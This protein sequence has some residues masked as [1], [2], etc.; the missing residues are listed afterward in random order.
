MLGSGVG[1]VVGDAVT[2]LNVGSTVGGSVGVLVGAILG[3]EKGIVEKNGKGQYRNN[4]AKRSLSFIQTKDM[5]VPF[6]T[7]PRVGFAEGDLVGSLVG[8]SV[9]GL[10]LGLAVGV[11]D[12]GA[13]VD[14][15]KSE[16]SKSITSSIT[17]PTSPSLSSLSS[18][19]SPLSLPPFCCRPLMSMGLGDKVG[20]FISFNHGSVVGPEVE[21]GTVLLFSSGACGLS[22]RGRGLAPSMESS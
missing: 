13:S 3:E 15:G 12:A 6:Y 17:D 2:G 8:S 1:K 7:L 14:G 5:R 22:L 11:A 16:G 4:I 9:V 20:A 21:T 10:L 19:S 18:P